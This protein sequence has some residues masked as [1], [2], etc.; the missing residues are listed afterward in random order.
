MSILE[1]Y[2]GKT[3]SQDLREKVITYIEN[4]GDK[5]EAAKVFSIGLD[6]V[7]RWLRLRKNGD[8]K[9]KKRTSFYQVVDTQKLIDYIK[10][11][12][13]HTITEIATALKLGRQTVFRWLGRLNITRKKRLR[14]IENATR[15]IDE[16][17]LKK[18][19]Q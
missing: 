17:L 14:S 18:S 19:P 10:N 1:V 3:Y 2:M 16:N 15:K 13:D 6:T 4:H 5:K 7:Y 9:P 8:L 11:N 12:S